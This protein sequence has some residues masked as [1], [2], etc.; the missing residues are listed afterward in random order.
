[1][2]RKPEGRVGVVGSICLLSRGALILGKAGVAAVGLPASPNINS[3]SMLSQE[4]PSVWVGVLGEDAEP[5]LVV[6]VLDLP[7]RVCEEPCTGLVGV[8]WG[9]ALCRPAISRFLEGVAGVRSEPEIDAED[10]GRG[11][12]EPAEIVAGALVGFTVG[13]PIID[14]VL[15]FAGGSFLNVCGGFSDDERVCCFTVRFNRGLGGLVG[16]SED[17]DDGPSFA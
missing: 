9:V 3:T 1:V 14:V 4:S 5:E 10:G 8:I 16:E 15:V 17:E 11:T 7:L 2:G 12:A 13:G 6:V